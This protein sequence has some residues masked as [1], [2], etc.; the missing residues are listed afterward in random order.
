MRLL[1]LKINQEAVI[2][3]VL[4]K[5]DKLNLRLQ[6]LGLYCGS[7]ICILNFSPLKQTLLVKIFNSVFALKS[8]VAKQIEVEQL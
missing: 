3:K 1:D 8:E 7:K 5:D 2:K 4:L 6:E